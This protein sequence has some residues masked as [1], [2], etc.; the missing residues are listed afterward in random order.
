MTGRFSTCPLLILLSIGVASLLDHAMTGAVGLLGNFVLA[1]TGPK[2]S[3]SKSLLVLSSLTLVILLICCAWPWYGFLA[4]I[5]HHSDAEYWFNPTI[6][7]W[8]L[9]RWIAPVVLCMLFTIPLNARPL[10]RF[11][12]VAFGMSLAAGIAAMCLRSPVLARL[13][14]PAAVFGHP[15]VGVWVHQSGLL[16]LCTW[17]ARIN[18][19]ARPISEAAYPLLQCTV[20]ALLLY[21]LIP[22]INL[23]ASAPYFARPYLARLR[24]SRN[25]QKNPRAAF[26]QLLAPVQTHDV[27]LSDEQTSWLIPSFS[28]RI[29]TALHYELYV[30]DQPARGSAVKQFF[31]PLANE[32]QRDITLRQYHVSWIVLNPKNI[33]ADVMQ[34]LRQKY[35]TAGT[36]GDLVLLAVPGRIARQKPP[37]ARTLPHL[38]SLE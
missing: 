38:N 14:L 23:I 24:H 9:T 29:V 2:S 31:S 21:G 6:L 22:Q 8:L 19:L 28:G 16:R 30:P 18:A 27:V 15:A 20:A 26:N 3:R 32:A 33:N 5:R 34:Q 37:I 35:R 7:K 1:L 36:A 11:C 17:P 10:I 13:P 25:L 4:A 12:L